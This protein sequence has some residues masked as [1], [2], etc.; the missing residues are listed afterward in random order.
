MSIADRRYRRSYAIIA[1][2]ALYE[3][4]GIAITVA[5]GHSTCRNPPSL[6]LVCRQLRQ[7]TL[8]MYFAINEFTI[9]TECLDIELRHSPLAAEPREKHLG[10]IVAC[11]EA[12]GHDNVR[13]A[14]KF[15]LHLGKYDKTG[16]FVTHTPYFDPV[17]RAVAEGLIS[18][19][20]PVLP[21]RSFHLAFTSITDGEIGREQVFTF[22]YHFA[23]GDDR[24][25]MICRLDATLEAA[26]DSIDRV[27]DFLTYYCMGVGNDEMRRV[28]SEYY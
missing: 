3:P 16:G 14:A 7:E 5:G 15:T 24:E 21:I 9:C 10:A 4:D 8:K 1:E 22:H 2:L 27:E 6:P 23:Y 17:W 11:L 26:R 20:G 13:A 28:I 12:I 25:E 18:R 19:K